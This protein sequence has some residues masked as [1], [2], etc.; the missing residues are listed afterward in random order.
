MK[1]IRLQ[2]VSLFSRT[3][4][5]GPTTPEPIEIAILH[6]MFEEISLALNKSLSNDMGSSLLDTLFSFM[7]EMVTFLNL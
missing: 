3:I 6:K 4:S 1:S 5:L 2:R 7:D